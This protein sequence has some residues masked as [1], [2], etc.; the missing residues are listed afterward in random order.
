MRNATVAAERDAF[1]ESARVLEKYGQGMR[2]LGANYPDGPRPF[3]N[4]T[5]L[6]YQLQDISDIRKGL[7]R[8]KA[9]RVADVNILAGLHEAANQLE[10]DLVGRCRGYSRTLLNSMESH[11]EDL[12]RFCA[13]RAEAAE[14]SAVKSRADA[15]AKDVE[16]GELVQQ[17]A[18]LNQTAVA[19]DERLGAAESGCHNTL[20][21]VQTARFKRTQEA[22]LVRSTL[23]VL[24]GTPLGAY[25]KEYGLV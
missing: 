4:S 19:A 9:H 10:K 12:G 2:A 5:V 24:S 6:R 13:S 16:L 7:G 3:K 18:A 22:N 25:A 1:N 8:W 17:F 15:Q 11:A 23:L 14:K 21:L 20:L